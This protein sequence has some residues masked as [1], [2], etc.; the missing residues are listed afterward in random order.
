MPRD[1]P[2]IDHYWFSD[3]ELHAR[4]GQPGRLPLLTRLMA[5]AWGFE[6]V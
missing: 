4:L 5:V 6:H 3:P 2:P 1:L